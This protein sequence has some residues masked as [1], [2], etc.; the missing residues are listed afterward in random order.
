MLQ[1]RGPNTQN[2]LSHCLAHPDFLETIHCLYHPHHLQCTQI[3]LER[4]GREYGACF[5]QL[6]ALNIRFR[7]AKITPKKQGLFVTLWKRSRK[8][9]TEPYDLSDSFDLFVIST[10]QNNQWGQFVF[11]KALLHEKNI[12]SSAGKGG[13]R[14]LRLYPPW[15]KTL[16]IQAQKTQKW[17]L[18]YFLEVPSDKPIKMSRIQSLYPGCIS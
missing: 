10:R 17:Q 2:R 9:P 12:V 16:N 11:P 5:F 4:E 6:N 15:E 13:K 14:A 8:G 7:V 3:E 1:N 18:A